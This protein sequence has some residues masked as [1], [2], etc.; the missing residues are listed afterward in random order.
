MPLESYP[1]GPAGIRNATFQRAAGSAFYL[2]DI[3][4]KF[5]QGGLNV[6]TGDSGS[7]KSSLLL[8]L[9]G[10]TIKESGSVTRQQDAAYASQTAWLQAGTIMEN[11]LFYNAY[12]EKRYRSVISACCLDVD[13]A[14][15][16]LGDQTVV[17]DGGFAL[18]GMCK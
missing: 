11:I 12:N 7:G 16:E 13:L 5:N 15:I 8:A 3:N 2:R 1:H 18:S 14:E 4:I 17:G 9:L 10:E 6:V